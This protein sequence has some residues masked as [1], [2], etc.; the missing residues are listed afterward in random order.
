MNR[1][2]EIANDLLDILKKVYGIHPLSRTSEKQE[3]LIQT[4]VNYLEENLS[5]RRKR[6]DKD[7]EK[8]CLKEQKNS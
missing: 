2:D 5:L 1:R 3:E 7:E 6:K 8:E 4:M